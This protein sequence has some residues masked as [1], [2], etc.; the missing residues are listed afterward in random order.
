MTFFAGWRRM[1]GGHSDGDVWKFY[2]S[3]WVDSAEVWGIS[4]ANGE[5]F[6]PSIQK[7]KQAIC[8]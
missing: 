6:H 8:S 5:I 2:L 7:S 3:N 4:E 1:W